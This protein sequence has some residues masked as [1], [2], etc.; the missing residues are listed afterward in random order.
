M[1][2]SVQSAFITV[3][4]N[5]RCKTDSLLAARVITVHWNHVSLTEYLLFYLIEWRIKLDT[6]EVGVFC[7]RRI[8]QQGIFGPR[9]I[10]WVQACSR[11]TVRAQRTTTSEVEL[12]IRAELY[13]LRHWFLSRSGKVSRYDIDRTF[14]HSPKLPFSTALCVEKRLYGQLSAKEKPSTSIASRQLFA[15]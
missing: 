5:R 2:S 11:S 8:R 13:S 7:H 6:T 10:S 12:R 3:D 15:Q 1:H 9:R 14:V 4:W